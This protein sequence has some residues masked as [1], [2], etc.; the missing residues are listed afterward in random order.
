MNPT[1]VTLVTHDGPARPPDNKPADR[2]H[3]VFGMGPG[4][5]AHFVQLL[6]QRAWAE[7][8]SQ[9]HMMPA[10]RHRRLEDGIMAKMAAGLYEWGEE[11][12]QQIDGTEIGGRLLLVAR[13]RV[14]NPLAT[15]ADAEALIKEYG[16]KRIVAA[17][18]EADG[19]RDFLPNPPAPEPKT[20]GATPTTSPSSAESSGSTQVQAP[21]VSTV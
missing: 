9:R 5:R 1:S 14:T 20:S 2:N 18:E 17:C 10:D 7:L 4:V 21:T 13:L 15:E 16:W 8:D 6:K 19:P 12:H 11:I 3:S